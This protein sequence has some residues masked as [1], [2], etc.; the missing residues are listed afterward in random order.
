MDWAMKE[1]SYSQRRACAL[2]GI[3]PRVYWR[4]SKRLVDTELR[5]KM[6]ELAP[7][8]RRF[9]YRR[10]NILLKREGWQVNWKNPSTGST[11]KKA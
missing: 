10:L 1:K 3:D 2:A 9:G 7:E 11:A 5:A 8:R 4:T 6:K